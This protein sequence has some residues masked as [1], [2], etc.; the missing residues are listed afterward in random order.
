MWCL[1]C[2]LE[3]RWGLL[4]KQVD[5]GFRIPRRVPASLNILDLQFLCQ[6]MDIII[7]NA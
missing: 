1:F 7:V 5:L 2:D 3:G 4:E 6:E